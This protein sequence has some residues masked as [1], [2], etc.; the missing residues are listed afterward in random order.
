MS[1]T[2]LYA[3]ILGP[4]WD[5]LPAEIRDLHDTR[6]TASA[7]G[8]AS[9]DRGP[10]VLAGLVAGLVGFPKPTPDVAVSVRFDDVVGVETWTRTFGA[11]R[12][13][14][15]QFAGGAPGLMC[16]VFGPITFT[17]AL[18]WAEGRLTLVL[19]GWRV[20]GLPMPMWLCARSNSYE[21]VEAGRFRFHVDIS[22]PL[23][24]PIIR[25]RG[26]L[27]PDTAPF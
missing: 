20:L 12:F 14:T 3:R 7:T 24:G 13:A 15:R 10:G 26:W 22:H 17:M 23:T 25:Y 11:A 16:E 5:D 18:V 21:T 27:V 19:R 9:V 2:P 6:G 4:V 1:E 8:R